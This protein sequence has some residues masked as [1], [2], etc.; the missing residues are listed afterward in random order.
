MFIGLARSLQSSPWKRLLP[1]II[2]AAGQDPS[3]ADVHAR[4]TRDRRASAGAVGRRAMRRGEV[5]ART[6]SDQVIEAIAGPIYYRVLMTREPV[7]ARCVTRVVDR[8]L[9]GNG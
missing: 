6:Q 2:G 4:F 1:S 3:I 5:P 7:P 8:A 9:A